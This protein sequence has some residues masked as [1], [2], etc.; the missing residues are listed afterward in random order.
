ML[1]PAETLSPA[2]HRGLQV[3]W[4]S[5]CSWCAWR[6]AN[7]DGKKNP[8]NRRHTC[9]H[10]AWKSTIH[11]GYIYNRPMDAM[12]Y[13]I[14]PSS[15]VRSWFTYFIIWLKVVVSKGQSTWCFLFDWF[16]RFQ[17]EPH[18]FYSMFQETLISMLSFCIINIIWGFGC[19]NKIWYSRKL[20]Y[21]CE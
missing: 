3:H 13:K 19:T 16:N 1:P 14:K 12:G 2:I 5:K 8:R 15:C 11:A 7:S 18:Q 9:P 17:P 6:G 4:F 20:C 10:V 21:P